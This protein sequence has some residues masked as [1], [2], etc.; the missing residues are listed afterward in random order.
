M[1]DVGILRDVGTFRVGRVSRKKKNSYY[2]VL[3]SFSLV[4]FILVS[5]FYLS[6]IGEL[7]RVC[8]YVTRVKNCDRQRR[9]LISLRPNSRV[10]CRS[11]ILTRANVTPRDV[12][13]TLSYNISLRNI[14][15]RKKAEPGRSNSLRVYL[16]TTSRYPGISRVEMVR[17]SDIS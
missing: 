16:G 5:G 6:A 17:R 11:R 10:C 3:F 9:H 8:V 13:G 4:L 7:T 1:L 2:S 14:E 15:G 12:K